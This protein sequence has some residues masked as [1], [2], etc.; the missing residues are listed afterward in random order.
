[1]A[2]RLRALRRED[3]DT[4]CERR[5]CPRA[6]LHLRTDEYARVVKAFHVWRGI[7]ERDRDERGLRRDREIERPAHEAD[8]ESNR[9]VTPAQLGELLGEALRRLAF[10]E[11]E[12]AE[13]ACVADRPRERATEHPRQLGS[14]RRY[15]APRSARSRASSRA[16]AASAAEFAHAR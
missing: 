1:M 12:H 9:R 3:I 13:G 8:T 4:R 15:T 16:N 10:V 11:S 2:T 7:A 6:R 14:H 5:S